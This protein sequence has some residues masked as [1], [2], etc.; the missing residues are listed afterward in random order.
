M[1]A[2]RR[3]DLGPRSSPQM[4][5][6]PKPDDL[7]PLKMHTGRCSRRVPCLGQSLLRLFEFGIDDVTAGLLVLRRCT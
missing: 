4:Q 3:A 1:R 7:G 2:S 5:N 6:G